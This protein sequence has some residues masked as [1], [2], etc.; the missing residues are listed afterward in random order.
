MDRRRFLQA[1]AASPLLASGSLRAVEDEPQAPVID[2]HLHCFAGRDDPRFPYHPDGPY[3]PEEPATPERLLR[4]MDGA[5]VDYAVVVHPEPYQDDHRY[6]EHCLDVGG[7]KLKGTC[8]FFADEPGSLDRMT[9]LVER[10][11][12]QIVAARIHAYA[13]DRLPPFGTPE[14]RALWEH[15]GELGLAVQLHFEPRYAPGFEPL[16]E[17]F[18]E[19][20]VI[21]DHLGRP[22]QG[23]PEEHAVVV[24]WSRYP[25]TVMKLSSIPDQRQYPHRDIAPVIR[26]LTDSYGPDRL[27][28]GGGFNA[29]ATGESYRAYRE[30][31]RSYLTHLTPKEQEKVLGGNAA[32]LFGFGAGGR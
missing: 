23:T 9:E 17:A 8:L 25:N 10:R 21:I 6:L 4:L 2:T 5:G 15:I 16:I 19:T 22:F 29:E 1:A 32:R 20:T 18:P 30:R 7:E 31:L 13:P 3:Q 24:G 27:I 26:T 11:K 14:L 28:Y 12:G